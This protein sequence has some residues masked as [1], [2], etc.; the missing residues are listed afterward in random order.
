VPPVCSAGGSGDFYL[1]RGNY[2]PY[3]NLDPSQPY[4]S[5]SYANNYN[6]EGDLLDY[7]DPT[8]GG[9]M[10]KLKES[11][12]Y[13]FGMTMEFNFLMPREGYE[14][15]SPLLY[16]FNG[17]DDLWIFID[18]VL[19]LDLGGV[20]DAWPG[21]INFATGEVTVPNGGDARN[22][23]LVECFRRAGVFPNGTKWDESMVDQYFNIDEEKGIYTFVD[24]GSH[25]FKMFYMEHGDGASNLQ[26]RFN[27]PVIEQGQFTVA[28]ELTGTSQSAYANVAFAYQAYVED[29]GGGYVLAHDAVYGKKLNASGAEKIVAEAQAQLD[30]W[31]AANK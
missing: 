25:S 22:L 18:D 3:N 13:Y 20:H 26:M 9:T 4:A 7:E 16:E 31:R 11:V 1:M 21:T 6:G 23:N 12:N 5:S 30:A 27:L 14:N 15:G 17:D 24:Y 19:V 28:K 10:Y 8:L 29:N 2:L